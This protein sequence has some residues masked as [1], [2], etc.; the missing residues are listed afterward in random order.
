MTDPSLSAAIDDQHVAGGKFLNSPKQ[1]LGRGRRDES[2]IV[3]KRFLVHRRRYGW[4]LQNRFDFG[5]KDEAAVLLIKIERLD[6][7]TIAC[8][9]QLF[10]IGIPQRDGVITFDLPDKLE[11]AFLVKMQDRFRISAR[12]ID[13]PALFQPFAQ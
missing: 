1:S 4:V 9:H 12:S 6:A 3:I 7:R 8:E 10:A 5:S 2:Q 13:V 11:A